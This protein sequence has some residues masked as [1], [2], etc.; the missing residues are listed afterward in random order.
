MSELKP[1]DR[2][3]LDLLIEGRH[4]HPHAILG[5]HPHDGGV[6]VRVFK[7]LASS[8][9]VR[10]D[11]VETRLEH[12]YAGFWSRSLGLDKLDHRGRHQGLDQTRG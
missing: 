5:P 12:E 9:V 11:G 7:P 3:E 4:G 2:H 10:H 8:V 6:T 1:V